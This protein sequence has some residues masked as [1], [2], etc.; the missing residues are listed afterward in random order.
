ME[1]LRLWA[2]IV[3]ATAALLWNIRIQIATARRDEL[4]KVK[5]DIEAVEAKLETHVST[6]QVSR[7]EVADRLTT[8]EGQLKH[9]PDAESAHRMEVAIARLEGNLEVMA[10]RLKPVAAISERL[11]EFLLE[12]AKR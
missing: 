5:G 6:G 9:L 11:Q 1:E 10:E 8:I 3:I 12:Q 4:D 2:P 7:A